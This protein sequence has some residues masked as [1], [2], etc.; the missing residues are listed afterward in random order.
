VNKHYESIGYLSQFPLAF[1]RV[2][3]LGALIG[4]LIYDFK[5]SQSV[6]ALKAAAGS[7]VGFFG[8]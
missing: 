8:I 3:F 7:F 5:R 6:S 1:D 2:P 4:E